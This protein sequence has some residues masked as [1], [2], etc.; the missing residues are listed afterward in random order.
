MAA[1]AAEMVYEHNVQQNLPQA[2]VTQV[3][4]AAFVD[5]SDPTKL[6]V[7]SA[8]QASCAGHGRGHERPEE[9]IARARALRVGARAPWSP[10]AG[11]CVVVLE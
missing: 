4:Q 2:V 1:P 8:G 3:V 10:C 7:P 9:A 6:Y 5:P 11:L